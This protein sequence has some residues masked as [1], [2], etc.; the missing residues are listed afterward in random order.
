M[1]NDLEK[2][3]RKAYEILPEALKKV[4]VSKGWQDEVKRIAVKYDFDEEKTKSLEDEVM[5]VLLGLEL[6]GDFKNNLVPNKTQRIEQNLFAELAQ[7]REQSQKLVV[8]QANSTL[9][10]LFWQVGKRIN[11]NILQNKRADY[12]K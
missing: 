9:T 5:Y 12:G 2:Q 11:D 1:E 8:S 7:L 4:I 6:V 3:L 10:L